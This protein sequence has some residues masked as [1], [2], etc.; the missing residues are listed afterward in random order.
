MRSTLN[1]ESGL[2]ALDAFG[3]A[4]VFANE[5]SNYFQLTGPSVVTHY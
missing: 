3:A 1:V 2:K 4:A 5:A